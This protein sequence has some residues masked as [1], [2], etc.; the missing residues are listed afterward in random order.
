MKKSPPPAHPPHHADLTRFRLTSGGCS[1]TAEASS[2]PISRG[3]CGTG[4]RIPVVVARAGRRPYYC[5]YFVRRAS[6]YLPGVPATAK[7]KV[8]G[9]SGVWPQGG[10]VPRQ[11][12]H[13][14][15]PGRLQAPQTLCSPKHSTAR[16]P[17]PQASLEARCIGTSKFIS[18]DLRC[19]R[20]SPPGFGRS[21]LERFAVCDG[22]VLEDDS[23]VPQPGRASRASSC[24]PFLLVP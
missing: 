17:M 19:I 5:S 13:I 14:P 6:P 10:F 21:S 3:R 18:V 9:E 20:H 8:V 22:V 23:N 4:V 15:S 1:E 16:L 7:K 12:L 2:K 24:S 11:P